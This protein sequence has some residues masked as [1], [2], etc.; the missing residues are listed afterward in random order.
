MNAWK[1][2]LDGLKVR[3]VALPR[4]GGVLNPATARKYTLDAT[5]A[6]TIRRERDRLRDE[7]AVQ[8]AA[9][10]APAATARRIT[11]IGKK[12]AP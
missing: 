5:V 6:K 4:D 12:A 2:E 1:D 11:L 7:A 9:K 8:Q 3:S 10:P